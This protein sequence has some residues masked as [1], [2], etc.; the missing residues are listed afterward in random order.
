M[1]PNATLSFKNLPLAEAAVRATFE[2]P[3]DLTISGINKLHATI[4]GNFPRIA[5][6]GMIEA[7]PGTSGPL[8]L[9][10]GQIL[11]A[12]FHDDA[13]GL[14][15]SLQRQV[16]VARWTRS[17]DPAGPDYPRYPVLRAVLWRVAGELRSVFEPLPR[18]TVTNMSY[19]NF[20]DIEHQERV[21]ERYF[22]ASM[23]VEAV[24]HAKQLRKLE[25]SWQEEDDIDLRMCLEQ[26]RSRVMDQE[27]EGYRLTTAGG[28]R[29]PPK[30]SP[31]QSLDRVHG[32]LQEFFAGLIS[33]DA[34]TQW[35]MEGAA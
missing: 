33:N 24:R 14:A 8:T 32:R 2:S 5:E 31:E 12:I 16:L 27:V 29:L 3:I 15:I 13:R 1:N 25:V 6:P 22:S 9:H 11:G 28:F 7:A 20:L 35:Q 18:F 17:A 19:V 21:L 23:Q 34:K 26:A 30:E 4:Q 10:P